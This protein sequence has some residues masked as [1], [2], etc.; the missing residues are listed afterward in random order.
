MILVW[1]LFLWFS[2]FSEKMPPACP[3]G[4]PQ[5]VKLLISIVEKKDLNENYVE[6]YFSV[7]IVLVIFSFFWTVN[8]LVCVPP[9]LCGM[10]PFFQ[11]PNYS[12][13]FAHNSKTI[14][15]IFV[16]F[17]EIATNNMTVNNSKTTFLDF[18]EILWNC[19]KQYDCLYWCKKN[20]FCSF[21]SIV[22]LLKRKYYV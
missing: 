11:C 12:H 4:S 9:P 14:R 16:K 10:S 8:D 1:V 15:S 20:F 18:C 6:F 22:W 17:W 7:G 3:P 13:T 5:F 21:F 19:Y 2:N